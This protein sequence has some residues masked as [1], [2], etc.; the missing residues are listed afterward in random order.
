MSEGNVQL[1]L[2]VN[3]DLVAFRKDL[4]KLAQAAA[5]YY[6]P[7]NLQVNKRN[8]TRQLENIGRTLGTRKY[9]VNV[10]DTSIKAA[11]IQVDRLAEKLK[12]LSGTINI[13][14][15]IGEAGGRP[16]TAMAVMARKLA[17]QFKGTLTQQPA[18]CRQYEEKALLARALAASQG[19]RRQLKEWALKMPLSFS[20]KN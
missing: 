19:S 10:D 5:A 14:T 20:F 18:K 15:N 4:G 17:N 13:N 12:R 6:Y 9:N 2:R 11:S 16:G 3:L 7:I 1:K 8:F